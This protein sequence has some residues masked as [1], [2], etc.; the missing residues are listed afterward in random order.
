MPGN[1]KTDAARL[2][3]KISA[4]NTV[5][6]EYSG[7]YLNMFS[8]FAKEYE[9]TLDLVLDI[10]RAL[11][12]SEERLVSE[13]IQVV[14]GDANIGSIIENAYHGKLDTLEEKLSL[15]ESKSS[16][17]SFLAKLENAVKGTIANILT[18]F[19]SCSVS[20]FIPVG[21]LDKICKNKVS[22]SFPYSSVDGPIYIPT[23]VLDISN[24][25]HV[26]PVGES[27][28]YFYNTPCAITYY[29]FKTLNI[30]APK[31]EVVGDFKDRSAEKR[32]EYIYETVKYDD[33]TETDRKE[34]KK[35]VSWQTTIERKI[36]E[37]APDRV[38]YTVRSQY[39]A[40]GLYK[41]DDMNAFIWYV[42]NRGDNFDET[43]ETNADEATAVMY[44]YNKMAWDSRRINQAESAEARMPSNSSGW[45]QWLTSRTSWDIKDPATSDLCFIKD[46]KSATTL[47]PILQ[48]EPSEGYGAQ[49]HVMAMFPAQT[50]IRNKTTFEGEK[51]GDGANL[52]L[53]M[54]KSIYKFNWD[55]L[56]S[57][58][59]FNVKTIIMNLLYELN[60]ICPVP[61]IQYN[62]SLSDEI[63]DARLSTLI[64]DTIT[65]DD[66]EVDDSYYSFSNEDYAAAL[67][68]TELK[69]YGA[70]KYDTAAGAAIQNPSGVGL[71]IMNQASN[72]ATLNEITS[73]ITRGV[74]SVNGTSGSTGITKTT[75]SFNLA[76][77]SNFV[78][79]LLFAIT[80][81]F[82][83]AVL[84]PQVMLLFCINLETMGLINLKDYARGDIDL[85]SDFIFRKLSGVFK[86]LIIQ[87]KDTIL[88]FLLDLVKRAVKD[89][90]DKVVIIIL[91][92]QMNDYIR[93]LEQILEC[94]RN[95]GIG[96]LLNG[97]D[98]V[99]Y[100][101]IVPE[102]KIPE[103]HR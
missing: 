79:E 43:Q 62:L 8:P 78:H 59:L 34:M 69:K 80:R 82:V 68:A 103:N 46:G 29:R 6:L 102:A 70:K 88:G 53:F 75:L 71:D 73:M 12:Y 95:F 44:E 47:F 91:L 9:S 5:A 3:G 39:T 11:G 81:P 24:T 7:K 90:T 38:V 21:R 96:R 41:T 63:I 20:P 57:I 52:S 55:Y 49:E 22:T 77:E 87:I 100:A 13:I 48:L 51:E 18:S 54:T 2:F 94:I 97:I 65:A 67:K 37:P 1:S 72:A 58:K 40:E 15:I 27:G 33:L 35:V 66:K 89:L 60:G 101:D 17:D 83:R 76:M 61:D 25:L 86:N 56:N 99:Q 42:V 31:Q 93:L 74:Y 84:S 36:D 19:L 98:E 28:I 45:T 64:L 26:S 14:T 23:R 10:L 85:L 30:K 4:W 16:N 32:V 50:Y 92:E